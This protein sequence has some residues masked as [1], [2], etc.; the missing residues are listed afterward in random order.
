MAAILS[1]LEGLNADLIIKS[2]A[3]LIVAWKAYEEVKK[4]VNSI[5]D[6][7]DKEKKWDQYEQNLKEE[8]HKIYQ[9]YDSKLEELETKI[10]ENHCDTEAKIQEL[11]AEMLMMTKCMSA[12]L[13][14]LKQL[15]CNGSV[16]E[17]KRNLD[18]FLMAK[19]YDL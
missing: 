18:E 11:R 13:D 14:G 12:V 2:L 15:N 10:D 1:S 6:R 8:R 9:K 16:T 19:A 5:N 3:V 4:M 7:H 17:M